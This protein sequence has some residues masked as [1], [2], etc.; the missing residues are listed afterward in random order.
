M[1][2]ERRVK[3]RVLQPEGLVSSRTNP[4]RMFKGY[5]S[6]DAAYILPHPAER[7]GNSEREKRGALSGGGGI[8]SFFTR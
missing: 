5:F 4:P 3:G 7:K 6:D 8:F 1:H 2:G